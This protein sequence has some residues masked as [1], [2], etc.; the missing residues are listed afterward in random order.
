MIRIV[1]K[2]GL[3]EDTK[4]YAFNKKNNMF[5]VK[6]IISVEIDNAEATATIKFSNVQLEMAQLVEEVV[7]EVVE[8]TPE[9]NLEEIEE[10]DLESDWEDDEEIDEEE[11]EEGV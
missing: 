5:E 7:E 1:N 8:E 2:T 3:E 10:D 11:E 4:V 9:E 6:D